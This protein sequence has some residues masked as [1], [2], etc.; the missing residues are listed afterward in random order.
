MDIADYK[1]GTWRKAYRNK[2]YQY[3]YFL[4]E[5]IN[6]S[7][8]WAD[9]SI[10]ELLER[11]S[12]KLGELNSFSRFVPDLNMF[13][14]MHVYKEAV[15]SSRIE[16]TQ[17]NI[18]EAIVAE[19][20]IN[21]EKRDDWRE[22][23]NYVT[24][25]DTAIAELKTL[26]LSNRLIKNTHKILLSSGR[27]EQKHPGEFRQSQN[28][29]GGATLNDA[30][31]IPPAHTELP[32]LLADLELFLHNTEIRIPHLI[33]IAIAHY[34]F[35][36]IHP[37]LDGNGRMG[38][39]LITLY[40][41]SAGVLDMPL[42]YLSE[43]FEKNKN[44]YYDNL[45]LVRTKNDMGQWLKFFLI[46]VIQTSENGV[47]TLHK[48][49]ELKTT[50]EKEKILTMGKRAKQGS[51]LLHKLFSEPVVTVKDVQKITKLTPITANGLIQVFMAAGILK[52]TTGNQRNRVFIFEDY[53]RLFR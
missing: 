47:N 34:Q 23:N 37:F 29:I 36:T 7:F 46:G 53:L 9:E 15:T 21:P 49:T 42:L 33:R 20:E 26:P 43:Y 48:I 12:L 18:E 5:K 16:G 22:V 51:I 2:D 28:W 32:E 39:L 3:Q 30:L 40:L 6:H 27:G 8:V 38:R 10:N 31:F 25:M 13:I 50:I 14:K 1:A 35:E 19:K 44:L 41:V 11:A 17:T 24:A 52:E 45:E 4:P